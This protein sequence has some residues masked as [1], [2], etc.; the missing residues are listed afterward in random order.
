MLAIRQAVFKAFAR[1]VL[2]S[3]A[4]G[5]LIVEATDSRSESHHS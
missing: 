5:E 2:V 4:L 3:P 1:S